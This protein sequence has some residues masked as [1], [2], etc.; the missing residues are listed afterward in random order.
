VSLIREYNRLIFFFIN[1]PQ[2]HRRGLDLTCLRT[3][4]ECLKTDGYFGNYD[5]INMKHNTLYHE[6]A[7]V[8]HAQHQQRELSGLHNARVD[9][10][11]TAGTLIHAQFQD[12]ALEDSGHMG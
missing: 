8:N 5:C 1:N 11:V 10:S 7:L 9:T 6:N 4:T 3:L 12:I 2:S